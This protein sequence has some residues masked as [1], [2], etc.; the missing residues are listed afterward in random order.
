[1]LGRTGIG[2]STLAKLLL[3]LYDPDGR[4]RFALVHRSPRFKLASLR[5][6]VVLVT[7]EIQLFHASVRDNLSLFDPRMPD[8]RWPRG[9]RRLGLGDWLRRC[10]T[11]LDYAAGTWW[12]RHV[13]RR[14]ATAAF[15]RSFCV[16]PAL[17]ILDEASLAADPA[18]N[19]ASNGHRSAAGGSY[20]HRHRPSISDHRAR[21]IMC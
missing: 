6:R 9:A 15:A 3:R 14:G 13:R 4:P 20:R 17:V 5:Q 2:K 12:R 18:T 11:G 1:L 19:G 7:Q 8:A 21:P 10:P 16:I